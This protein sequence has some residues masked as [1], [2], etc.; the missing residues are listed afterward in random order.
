[1]NRGEVGQGKLEGRSD[2]GPISYAHILLNNKVQGWVG[3]YYGK[4]QADVN[5]GDTL[6]I[7]SIS[8]QKSVIIIPTDLTGSDYNIEVILKNDTVYLK[9][10]I[11]QPWPATFGKL[12]QELL[13]VEVVDPLANLDLHLPSP[14]ELKLLAQDPTYEPGQVRLYSGSGPF[15]LLYKK[16]SRGARSKKLH[17]KLM[18]IEK[19]G[20][21]YNRAIVSKITGLK[22]EGE[23]QKF[24]EFCALQI[25]FI[26][27]STD[28]EL[29]S[30]ISGC[31]DEYCNIYHLD[32]ISTE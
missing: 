13:D 7:T 24:M 25:K 17:A 26:L 20:K 22:D 16:F 5:P 18:K 14:E 12:R 2:R 3:D 19:V 8:Y 29:Y 30:A 32:S 4:F 28:Y 9:E 11:V 1:L 31:Y 21:R 15:S 6:T 10:L 23:I 27:E